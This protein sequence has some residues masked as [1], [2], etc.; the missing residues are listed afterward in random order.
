M[1]YGVEN[2][3]LR[4]LVEYNAAGM[5]WVQF[6]S[7]LQMPGNGLSLAVFIGC[8]PY[9]LGFLHGFL[10]VGHQLVLL[11]GDMVFGFVLVFYVYAH[12]FLGQIPDV[13]V[14]RLHDIVLA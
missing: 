4:N 11:L 7:L 12:L 9:R 5:F 10:Q 8:Q 3:I 14:A 1:L 6:Q 13:A 2:G